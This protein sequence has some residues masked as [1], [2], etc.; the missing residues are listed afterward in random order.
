MHYI[1]ISGNRREA[2][3]AGYLLEKYHKALGFANQ[4]KTE[5]WKI[6]SIKHQK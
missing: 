4:Q 3:Q 2:H 1:K 6:H 5:N